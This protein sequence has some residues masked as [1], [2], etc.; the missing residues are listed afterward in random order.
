MFLFLN[1]FIYDLT[2]GDIYASILTLFVGDR[3]Q[4]LPTDEEVVV[5][6][7]KTTAEEVYIY[8]YIYVIYKE[9]D[10]VLYH[11]SKTPRSVLKN[12]AV[13]RVY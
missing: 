7:K 1:I 12:K 2:L 8:I 11:G 5:C 13:G 3:D 10:S 6:N 4:R 9:Q